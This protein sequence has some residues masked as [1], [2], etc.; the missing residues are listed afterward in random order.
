MFKHFEIL[1][2]IA[3]GINLWFKKY[4]KNPKYG[5]S[6]FWFVTINIYKELTTND[7]YK[8]TE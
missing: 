6:R 5:D 3:K 1:C 7:Y 8:Q 4:N 2:V